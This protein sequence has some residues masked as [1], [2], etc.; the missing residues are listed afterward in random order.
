MKTLAMIIRRLL[1]TLILVYLGICAFMFVRERS[2]IYNQPKD[3]IPASAAYPVVEAPGLLYQW[4]APPTPEAPVVVFF[5]GNGGQVM[6]DTFLSDWVRE[7]GGGFAA[8][9]YPGYGLLSGETSEA[10]ILGAARAALEH[11]VQSGVAKERI[12][13]SGRSLGTGV[14]VAMAAEGWGTRVVLVSPY[15]SLP[16]VGAMDYPWLPVRLLMSDTF[17]SLTRAERVQVP[18]RV[19]HGD[20]DLRIPLA[21]GV[22]LAERLTQ[23]ELVVL[24]GA[25]HDNVWEHPKMRSSYVDFLV[26]GG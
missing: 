14:A 16:D 8:V 3:V 4:T 1:V 22:R 21:Q 19:I 18:V 6:R 25:D 23:G 26:N 13:L 9:E 20:Q 11:I 2:L 24:S 17:D 5:H 12:R 7:A 15:T 10:N